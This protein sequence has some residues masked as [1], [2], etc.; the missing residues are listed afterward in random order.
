VLERARAAAANGDWREAKSCF[1][2]ALAE[3]ETAEALEGLAFGPFDG[4]LAELRAIQQRYATE[5][6]ASRV[7]D[8]VAA[9][10]LDGSY[11][12]EEEIEL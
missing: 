6:P 7:G 3:G 5:T 11:E 1:E 10:P 9:T 8:F 4:D 2:P 12:V